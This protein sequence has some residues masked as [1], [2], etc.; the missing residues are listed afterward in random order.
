MPDKIGDIKYLIYGLKDPDTH[1]IRY[2]G[3]STSGLRRPKQHSRPA[4]YNKTWH[5]A[6][7]IKRLIVK[8]KRPEI[9]ILAETDLQHINTDEQW[10]IAYGRLSGWKL[11]NATDGGEGTV[12]YVMSERTKRKIGEKT[13]ARLSTPEGKKAH[14]EAHRTA[15]YRDVARKLATEARKRNPGLMVSG[16]SN[17]A[18]DP[19]IRKK[20]SRAAKKRWKAR[21]AAGYSHL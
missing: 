2:V 1:M 7:W 17:I 19:K 6:R 4:S 16:D 10:W 13:K 21:K 8:N 14:D 18:K 5:V 20:I 3:K 11:T 12:G 9:V 15:E